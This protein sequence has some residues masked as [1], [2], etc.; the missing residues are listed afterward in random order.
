MRDFRIDMLII[1][2]VMMIRNYGLVCWVMGV[3]LS[4]ALTW[5]LP[6][7]CII[8]LGLV[9][10]GL[11][12]RWPIFI[13]AIFLLLGVAYGLLRTQSAL[14]HQWPA[15]SVTVVPLEIRVV[16][17]P[18]RDEWRV[19]FMVEAKDQQGK[20]YRLQLADYH[21]R[22]W[23]VGSRWLVEARVRSAVGMVNRAGF[24]REAWALANGIDGLGTVRQLR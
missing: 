18:I 14:N 12:F 21:S 22:D 19:R 6:W 13:L 4:F 11:A 10:I 3:I 15:D 9:F 20:S 7:W 17:L 23:P 5:L 24:N 1:K 16:D 8:L 2:W